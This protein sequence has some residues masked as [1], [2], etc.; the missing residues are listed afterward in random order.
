MRA[1]PR[2]AAVATGLVL[3]AALLTGPAHGLAPR[4]DRAA[5]T[6]LTLSGSPARAGEAAP[7]AVALTDPG[8]APLPGATVTVERRVAGV[9]QPLATVVTDA[10]GA[11]TAALP[12]STVPADNVVRAS[13]AGDGTQP[14]AASPE[15]QVPLVRWRSRLVL[16][17]P[18]KVKDEQSVT[19]SVSWTATSGAPVS[20]P[21]RV[22]ERTRRGWRAV[23]DLV[24]DAAGA[25]AVTVTPRTDTAYR[26]RARALDWVEGDTSARVRVDNVPPARP[27]SVRGAP[28]PRVRLPEQPRAV[29]AGADARVTPIPDGVWRSM[30]GRSWRPG[31]PVGREGLRLLRVNYV[32]YDGYRHRGEL[33]VASSAAPA[34]A[35]LF[36]ELHD[37]RVPV[38]SM[39]RVDRFGF[40]P[41][42]HGAN[43]VRSMAAGNTSAFNCRHVVGRPGVRSPHAWGRALDLNPWENP[44]RVG[45]R[46]LPNAWWAGRSHARI[47]WRGRGHAVVEILR[48]HGFRWTYGTMDSQHFDAP[49]SA[50][51]TAR[52]AARCAGVCH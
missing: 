43:D 30:V 25:A 48:R 5:S 12:M 19:L 38:R 9:W 41:R 34:F 16:D 1:S 35:S 42:L 4:L 28:R 24:T 13:Y 33:V 31:C 46:W 44:Y 40:S 22:Q 52:L 17:A 3:L 6:A 29:A 23:A 2:L 26:V 50:R 37:R 49:G 27:V 10:S 20:G 21:V 18:R 51:V 32:G 11:A 47:A 8:G 14:P 36:T 39:Y 45:G 7:L 15:V